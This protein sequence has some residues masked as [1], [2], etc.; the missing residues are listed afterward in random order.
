MTDTEDHVYTLLLF[1]K[2][3]INNMDK[4][5]QTKMERKFPKIKESLEFPSQTNHVPGKLYKAPLI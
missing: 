4:K 2:K 1:L 5:K 3:R